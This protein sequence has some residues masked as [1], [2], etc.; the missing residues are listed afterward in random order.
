MSLTSSKRHLG[1]LASFAIILIVV[2]QIV[3]ENVEDV[4]ET[5][6][7]IQQEIQDGVKD[8]G[9]VEIVLR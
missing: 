9:A 8:S 6:D 1:L 4:K 7:E 5:A 3:A 2:D